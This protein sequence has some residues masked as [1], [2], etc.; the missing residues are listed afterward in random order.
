MIFYQNHLEDTIGNTAEMD[1]AVKGYRL[2]ALII[3]K[4]QGMLQFPDRYLLGEATTVKLNNLSCGEGEV[5]AEENDR[6]LGSDNYY[7]N[8]LRDPPYEHISTDHRKIPP[9]AI[10]S[11]RYLLEREE[12]YQISQLI[13]LPPLRGSP[14]SLIYCPLPGHR[15]PSQAGYDFYP[16]LSK[17]Q[18]ER[19]FT[20]VGIRYYSY[21][22]RKKRA[23][24]QDSGQGTIPEVN[25]PYPLLPCG[26]SA[27]I[28][29]T[30]YQSHC[31][32]EEEEALPELTYQASYPPVMALYR[33]LTLLPSLRT[34]HLLRGLGDVGGIYPY[35]IGSPDLKIISQS[36][37]QKLHGGFLYLAQIP[38]VSAQETFKATYMSIKE[39]AYFRYLRY[40]PSPFDYKQSQEETLKV[41]VVWLRK[42]LM[43]GLKIRHQYC[44]YEGIHSPP[45]LSVW[46][47]DTSFFL[48]CQAKNAKV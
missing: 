1:K 21:L 28:M 33:A 45:L 12:L 40:R 34:D 42:I 37:Y 4:T 9:R 25:P 11:D 22:A 31:Y 19:S 14:S 26:K 5:G 43:I 7:S 44:W 38:L 36:L 30:T 20:E 23:H 24:L 6:T 15:I 16:S 18:K 10:E 13:L 39:E 47:K 48:I 35:Q 8:E 32:G 2:I 3:H 41:L 27:G 46:K 17:W 29:R